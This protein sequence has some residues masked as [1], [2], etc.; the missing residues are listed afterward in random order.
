[1][2]NRLIVLDLD[3]LK[4][5]YGAFFKRNAP[6][7]SGKIP[8]GLESLRV[9]AELWGLTDDGAREELV[10]HAPAEALDDLVAMF[11]DKEI[12]KKITNWLGTPGAPD[13]LTDAY[14]AFGA[15]MEAYD[16]VKALRDWKD[17]NDGR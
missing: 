3:G 11:T 8:S 10:E 9:Y 16:S 1:M 13:Y 7:S 6:I 12:Y 4:K 14:R 15:M 17:R 5:R 2:N